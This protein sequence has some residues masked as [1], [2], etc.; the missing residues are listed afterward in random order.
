VDT[1]MQAKVRAASV[2]AFPAV[3]RF[4]EAKRNGA[5]NTTAWVA[6]GVLELAFGEVDVES[7][8]VVRVPDEW[9]RHSS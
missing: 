5:F 1:D 4:Q 7:G 3:G 6:D 9:E 8:G 2:E